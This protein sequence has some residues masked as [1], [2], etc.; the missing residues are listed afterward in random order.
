[1]MSSAAHRALSS[2]LLAATIIP[3]NTCFLL[4]ERARKIAGSTLRSIGDISR[5]QRLVNN[6]KESLTPH[7]MLTQLCS[8]NRDLTRFCVLRM[9][10]AEVPP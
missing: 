1:M 4:S 7:T 10:S 2:E 8:D 9:R 5:Q 6:D 3:S